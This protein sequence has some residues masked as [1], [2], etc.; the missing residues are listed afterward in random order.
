M[1]ITLEQSPIAVVNDWESPGYPGGHTIRVYHHAWPD[2]QGEG[3][4]LQDAATDLLRQVCAES[5][6]VAD[7]WH[8]EG[9][10][11]ILVDIRA[12]LA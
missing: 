2:L 3:P 5:G 8:R 10:E 4:T 1:T 12:F 6:C 9:L 7:G 11:S